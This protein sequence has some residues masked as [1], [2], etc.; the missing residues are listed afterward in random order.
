MLK[1]NREKGTDEELR[2]SGEKRRKM[3]GVKI[4]GEVKGKDTRPGREERYRS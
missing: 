2:T 4:K 1:T 3:K